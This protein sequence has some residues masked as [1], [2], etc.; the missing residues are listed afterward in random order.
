MSIK[1]IYTE[2]GILIGYV[3]EQ[4]EPSD[5]ITMKNPLQLSPV[6][7]G[8]MSI[9]PLLIATDEKTVTIPKSRM[10]LENLFDPE[11]S[12]HNKYN[13]IFGTGIV[14]AKTL[15]FPPRKI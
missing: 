13:E 1:V 9:S 15:P 3:E 12:I 5:S 6:G 2:F 10:L 14:T 4:L 8:R 7:E 11:L